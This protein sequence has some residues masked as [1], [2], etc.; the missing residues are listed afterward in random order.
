MYS[1]HKY[2]LIF[3]WTPGNWW[4]LGMSECSMHCP[5]P[6][7]G[8]GSNEVTPAISAAWQIISGNGGQVPGALREAKENHHFWWVC[9]AITNYPKLQGACKDQG[10]R[11]TGS[12]RE[13]LGRIP[14]NAFSSF[15]SLPASLGSWPLLPSA[16]PSL[17]ECA[18]LMASLLPLFSPL[19]EMSIY[20]VPTQII[21][22]NPP[23]LRSSG[24]YL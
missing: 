21:Q 13:A 1:F 7:G 6:N 24:E 2:S 17:A 4:A 20:T 16:K 18:T 3:S 12:S 22:D 11:G 10:V 5:C 9:A 14:F 23:I 8:M 15:W 19:Q